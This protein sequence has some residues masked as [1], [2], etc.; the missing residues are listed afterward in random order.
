MFIVKY[1]KIFYIISSLVIIASIF[2][3]FKSGLNLGI[4]FTGGALLEAEYSNDM[5]E[6]SLLREKIGEAGFKSFRLQPTGEKGIVLR[7]ATLTEEEHQNLLS[8]L[9]GGDTYDVIEKRFD[10]VGPVIGGELK[11][12][13]IVSI[14]LVVLL[15][16]LFI[17][18][19]FRGV[20]KPVSSWRYGIVAIIA[21]IHDVIVPVGVFAFIGAE[22]DVLFVTALL[23]ILGYSVNDTIIIFD[24]IR[25]NIKLKISNDFEETV[26]TS[27]SQTMARSINT[28]LTTLVVLG[29]LFFLGGNATKMFSL[30]LGV[31]II[32]GTY[33][34]IFLAGPLLVT[35]QKL[36]NKKKK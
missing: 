27:L 1:R 9:K 2:T 11:R 24:R 3:V 14:G 7:T 21:L 35:I 6:I 10:S 29:F 17:A 33:S 34:S 31:G 30:T 8:V 23:A 32:A 36:Q 25:E 13:A 22:V 5:P 26:G 15:I 12:K 28:S 18:F 19:A 20:A 4:D 16:I